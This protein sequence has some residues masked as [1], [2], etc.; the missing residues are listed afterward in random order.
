MI[1]LHAYVLREL[2][3]TFGLAVLALTAVFTMGGGLYNLMRYEGVSAAD[4]FQVMPLLIP[5]VVTLTMPLAALFAATMVYGRFAADNELLA[6]RAAG[7]NVYRL[8]LSAV[9]LSVF[10]AA[11]TLLFGNFVIPDFMKRLSHFA[12]ANLRDIAAQRLQSRG[13]VRYDQSREKLLLTAERTEGVA[14]AAL[15]EKH[16][17]DEPGLS[18]LLITRPTFLQLDRNGELVRY[19]AARAGLCQF[20]TRT[21]PIQVSIYVSDARDFEV[22]KRAVH[23]RDQWIGPIEVPLPFPEKPSMVDL[24]TL[25][26]WQREP[27]RAQKLRE[28]IRKKSFMARVCIERFAAYCEA[29]IRQGQPLILADEN[30]AR[31]SI[32][33]RGC[34]IAADGRPHLSEVRVEHSRSGEQQPTI[35]A[36]AEAS[37][38]LRVLSPGDPA[39]VQI[40]VR[41]LRTPEQPV[42]E[43]NP[44]SDDYSTPRE[45]DDLSLDGALLP[46]TVLAEL[47][48]YTPAAILD[49]TVELPLSARLEDSRASLQA[50]A[51]KLQRKVAA[52]IHFRLGSSISVLVTVLMGAALGAI[53]RGG[54][55]LAAFGLAFIPF[56]IVAILM[57]M[58]KQLGESRGAELAGPLVTWGGLL[59]VAV[60]DVFIL[61]LGIRR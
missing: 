27:W 38:I 53:F 40:E 35:F 54:R 57:V 7:V 18:Y 1:T 61:R 41:L 22:G 56:G 44:R 36:A 25:R 50:A 33:A 26:L 15:R 39:A 43:Y 20:D 13:Y 49:L 10:V 45:K 5:V 9:L 60:A 24:S 52:L 17:P 42:R 8:F 23:I 58:G 34:T 6:C 37:L 32:R 4:L 19:T 48:S 30:G 14:A 47:R 46:E 12:R 3:K 55:A 16:L 31:F 51:S 29:H 2:L 59:F 21:T 28:E 11:F